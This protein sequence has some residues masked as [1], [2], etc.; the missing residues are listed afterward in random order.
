MQGLQPEDE[1]QQ[2]G[3]TVIL[4]VVPVIVGDTVSVAVI[5]CFPAV[6][7]VAKKVPLPLARV[8]SG[9]RTADASVHVK[10]TVPE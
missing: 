5:V 10:W 6:L 1:W 9:G 7:K 3:R 8:V 4:P 2:P